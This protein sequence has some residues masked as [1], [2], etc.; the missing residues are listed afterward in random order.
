MTLK[1]L[2]TILLILIIGIIFLKAIRALLSLALTIVILYFAYY[3]F[4]TYPGAVKFGVFRKTF[5]FSSYKIDTSN[6][7]EEK[8]YI[9]D[10]TLNVGDYQISEIDCTKYGPT[11]ICNA[12]G[13]KQSN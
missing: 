4:F 13:E 10:P 1:T 7:T 6:Y 11:I 8:Q 2:L 12:K 9:L 3:T 5:A